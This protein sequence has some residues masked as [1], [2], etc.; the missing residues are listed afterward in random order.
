VDA[1]MW[2]G[3]FAAPFAW[4]GQHVAGVMLTIGQCHDNTAGPDWQLH[5]DTWAGI[6]TAAAALI[7]ALGLLSAVLAWRS[8]READDDDPPPA[9]R[10]HFLG[11]VG[12]TISPLFLAII[13][14]SG[15][16]TVFLPQCVQS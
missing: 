12:L 10:V 15:L 16:G 7:A 13:L 2:F 8:T 3:L 5:V 14:M 4:A 11:V 9:G 1:L 6:V